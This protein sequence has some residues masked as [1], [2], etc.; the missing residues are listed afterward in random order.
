MKNTNISIKGMNGETGDA[1]NDMIIHVLPASN[2]SNGQDSFN[3]FKLWKEQK[4]ARAKESRSF[5]RGKINHLLDE[6]FFYDFLY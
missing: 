4:K 3:T 1:A 6:I 2:Q 5:A